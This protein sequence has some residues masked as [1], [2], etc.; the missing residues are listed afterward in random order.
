[1]TRWVHEHAGVEGTRFRIGVSA[2]GHVAEWQQLLRLEVTRAGVSRITLDPGASPLLR[3]R[4]LRGPVPALLGHLTGALHWHAAACAYDEGGVLVLGDGG[5]GKST[6]V[7][8][9]VE[10][11]GGGFLG[12]DI[13]HLA[14]DAGTTWLHR[15]E[16]NHALRADVAET[17]FEEDR[18][19]GKVVRAPRALL[20]AAPLAA[21]VVLGH[22]PTAA[23][24][25]ALMLERIPPR[26]RIVHLLRHLVRFDLED[27]DR[28]ARD[29]GA[30]LEIARVPMFS[31]VRP[32]GGARWNE[33]ARLLR[34]A[35]R[36]TSPQP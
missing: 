28:A 32:A 25:A 36:A 1:M 29:L 5:A 34:S 22:C 7:A 9:L 23:A 11:T 14:R 8:G 35:L 17:L 16:G 4:L 26:E 12:D 30:V 24:D 15:V 20:D 19:R 31:L 33:L 13:V 3:E 18:P 21:V 10:H 2:E 27:G 6:T